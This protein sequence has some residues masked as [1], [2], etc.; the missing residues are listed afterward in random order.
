MSVKLISITIGGSLV[1]MI[2][3]AIFAFKIA[4]YV[5]VTVGL[6]SILVI[7]VV[8]AIALLIADIQDNLNND[9]FNE[10][11]L[12]MLIEEIRKINNRLDEEDRISSRMD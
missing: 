10:E 8:Y 12:L 2:L 9:S 11:M 6:G 5:V 7:C 3:F 1:L 4:I